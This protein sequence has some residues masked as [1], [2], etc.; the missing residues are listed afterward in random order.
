M[1]TGVCIRVW[2]R[3]L[4]NKWGVFDVFQPLRQ[5]ELSVHILIVTVRGS[6]HSSLESAKRVGMIS[7]LDH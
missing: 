4:D 7:E 1:I 2:W 3:Y 6:A 5:F